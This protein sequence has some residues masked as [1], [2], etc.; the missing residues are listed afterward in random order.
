MNKLLI[1]TSD[2][3]NV[4]AKIVTD[5]NEYI[6]TTVKGNRNPDSIVNLIEDVLKKS[7]LNLHDINGI[8][9]NEGPGSFTGL[10]VGAS[11]AN[12]LSFA[13]A[14]K[15]NNKPIGEIVEPTY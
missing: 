14:K 13:L 10:K 5:E 9:I 6:S 12:A 1:D 15:I 4:F 8:D 2:N 11:V 7:G 3:K